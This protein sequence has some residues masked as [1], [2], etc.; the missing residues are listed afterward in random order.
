M[1]R[2]YALTAA[3]A[4]AEQF[5]DNYRG[6]LPAKSVIIKND[7]AA[8]ADSA[9]VSF[10]GSVTFLEIKQGETLTLDGGVSTPTNSIH[11]KKDAAGA[12]TPL[13]VVVT[14]DRRSAR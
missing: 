10:D 11:Y 9:H 5:F 4:A 3:A 6:S 14:L 7:G 2:T 13:R 8:A 1:V 12:D